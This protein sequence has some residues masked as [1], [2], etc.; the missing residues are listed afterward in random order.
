MALHDMLLASALGFRAGQR[1]RP[2]QAALRRAVSTAY[3]AL[4]HLLLHE[5][6]LACCPAAPP[7]LR[8]RFKRAL[9]HGEMKA[10]CRAIGK[11]QWG[12]S[13][14]LRSLLP[15]SLHPDLVKVA[16]CF[17]NLQDL[18]QAADYDCA[19]TFTL[20]GV[21]AEI[22]NVQAAFAAWSRVRGSDDA[23]VMLVAFLANKGWDR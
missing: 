6:A 19:A 21:A 17:H 11:G 18:R 20:S 2:S 12:G 4:F 3:Y 15:P 9:T 16:A 23:K 10:V 7:G 8:D 1:G 14:A 22:T 13:K 5:A